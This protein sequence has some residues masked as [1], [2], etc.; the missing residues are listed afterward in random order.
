M[1][2]DTNISDE[3][4]TAYLDGALSKLEMQRIEDA[5]SHDPSLQA[6]LDALD[7]PIEGLRPA[8]DT[9]LRDMPADLIPNGPVYTGIKARTAS[10]AA[11]VALAAGVA[12][13]V[14]FGN[15]PSANSSW[16]DYVAAYQ[17]L[18]V[19]D[20]LS[21]VEQTPSETS[22]QLT[23]VS[24]T[25]GRELNS[26]TEVPGLTYKR[27]QLLGFKGKP[28]V[29]LAYVTENGAPIALCIIKS[30]DSAKLATMKLEDLEAASWSDGTYAYLLIGGDS[31]DQIE[32]MAAH[33]QAEL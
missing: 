7:A 10:I 33:L 24:Q 2:Q 26:A 28:L 27:A 32:A 8:F 9:M 14:F 6:Q 30:K 23:R 15:S 22:S 19:A 31:S 21:V 3:T 18:Y 12:L 20:T 4:L 17:A 11:S 16:H 1:T 25:L 29:Q 5:L 13:G